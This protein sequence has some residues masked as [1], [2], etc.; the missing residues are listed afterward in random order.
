M[1]SFNRV[2]YAKV[3][4]VGYRLQR[5]EDSQLNQDGTMLMDMCENV[6]GQVSVWDVQQIIRETVA[7]AQ[8]ASHDRG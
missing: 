8:E 3:W 2:D 4:L 5:R 1:A 7:K 6:I